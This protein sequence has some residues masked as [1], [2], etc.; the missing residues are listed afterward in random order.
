METVMRIGG[1]LAVLGLALLARVAVGQEVSY[2]YD[3][4]ASF[5]QY[6]TYAWVPGHPV[7]DQ[8]NHKRIVAAI[9]SQL[10]LKGF[11]RVER[12]DNPDLLVAYHA[13]FNK[14][15][16]V[17]GFSSGWGGYRFASRSGSARAEEIVIGTLV[18]DLVQ[19]SDKT[20]VWRGTAS[21]QIDGTASPERREKN[22]NK[23]AEKLF[24]NY[25]PKG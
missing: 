6:R 7:E 3:K 24:K 4:A 14:N 15:L 12:T 20:I 1:M 13:S 22:I 17:T 5:G 19:A 10:A 2:D 16:Q 21:K 9:D 8:L 11:T 25:P 23:A 18:V